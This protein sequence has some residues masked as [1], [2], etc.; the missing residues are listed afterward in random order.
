MKRHVRLT[1]IQGKTRYFIRKYT[2]VKSQNI[3][4]TQPVCILIKK[5]QKSEFIFENKL[6]VR[7]IQIL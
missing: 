5:N 6:T 3:N 2:T 7:P 4:N 1:I